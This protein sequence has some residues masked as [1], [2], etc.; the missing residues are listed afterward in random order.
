VHRPD[1]AGAPERLSTSALTRPLLQDF[2]LR[3]DVFVG[4]PAEVA[5]FAQIASLHETLGVPMPRIALRGHVLVAPGAIVRRFSKYA[6]QP[7]DVFTTPEQLLA[8]RQPEDVGTI[9]AIAADAERELRQ[10]AERIRQL[11]MPADHAIA[12]SINRSIG[13][14]EYHF[15]K[16][17]DRSI[18]ALVRKDRERFAAAR[19]LVS[20]FFPDRHVQDRIAA[21]VP[22]WLRF[23]TEL[24]DRMVNEVEPDAP[25]FKI[26]S[27]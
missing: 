22:F 27:L 19:E 10:H 2:V 25:F 7:E 20:A 24:I 17:T 26:V 6:I 14:I 12:R 3:P 23:G 21:W 9:R 11:A 16:F 5:Y 4:G 1:E 18:R 8:E 15:R 13:H